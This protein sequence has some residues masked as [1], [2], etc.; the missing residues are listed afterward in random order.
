M[1]SKVTVIKTVVVLIIL[2]LVG[3]LGVLGL[4][5]ARTYL[6]GATAGAEPKGVAVKVEDESVVIS[7]TTDKEALGYVQYGTT[8]ASLLLSVPSRDE[9]SS[10][11]I[12]TS[13]Q[14]NLKTFNPNTTYY[15]RIRSG[16]NP[17]NYTEWEVFDNGGIP[18][19]F[20]TKAR[21]AAVTGVPTIPPATSPT[22]TPLSPTSCQT[23]VDY[24]HDGVINSI[25]YRACL[26]AGGM[27]VPTVAAGSCQT[28]ID[29]DH[30]GT[31]NSL[32]IVKCRQ[33]AR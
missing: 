23:G 29:Y 12:K 27:A 15:F 19:S 14:I 3:V 24:N 1:T 8:P 18:Y 26:T 28:G 7:W 9:L 31:I 21:T 5:T 6:S 16:D 10:E 4:G 13:H 20:K 11:S 33:D 30:N 2:V 22:S 17:A 25:D 32:D